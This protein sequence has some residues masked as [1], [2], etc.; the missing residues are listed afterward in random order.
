MV[1]NIKNDNLNE[2]DN[3]LVIDKI[4]PFY[5]IILSL[6]R[7]KNEF[8]DCLLRTNELYLHS[9]TYQI[10]YVYSAINICKGSVYQKGK[11]NIY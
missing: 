9:P 4:D 1:K 2:L 3:D 7:D 10:I 5:N 8:I 6:H 11:G